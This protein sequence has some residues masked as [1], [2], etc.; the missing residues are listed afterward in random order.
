MIFYS[1]PDGQVI[2]YIV[3]PATSVLIFK[4]Q[5]NG[6]DWASKV[7]GNFTK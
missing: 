1:A 7:T 6:V 5:L 3:S 2:N 4:K